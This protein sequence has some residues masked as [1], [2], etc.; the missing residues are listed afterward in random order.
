[1]ELFHEFETYMIY[2]AAFMMAFLLT[3]FTTPYIRKFAFKIG[4]VDHPKDRGMH[5]K[6]M[7][8]AGGIAI[9]LGFMITVIIFMTFIP[10][11]QITQM[12]G[13]MVGATLITIVG[14]LDDIY[15][16]S[17]RIRIV[18]QLL[19]ALIVLMTGTVMHS[20]T[21]PFFGIGTL[22]LGIFGDIIT[23]FWIVGITNAV[24]FLDGL[25]GLAAGVSSIASFSLLMI[26][27][28]FGDPIIAGFAIL[29]TATLAGS[30]L[31]FLPHNF[32]PATIFMGDTGSTFLGFTL[33][34]IS[35]QTMLKTYTAL[36]LLVAAIV[37]GL[38]LFDTIF[39]I[40]RRLIN[41]KPVT[42]ADR[43]H[44]HHRLIDK[45][46]SQKKAVFT[47]YFVSGLFGVAGVLIA[48]NDIALA[49]VIIVFIFV[50]WTFDI[51]RTHMKNRG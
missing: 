11:E 39:A 12:V 14:L 4:A 38:P 26:A 3:N 2:I 40:F 50:V 24:N 1:M 47:L 30:C 20:I 35:I 33:A 29:L 43:G 5:T 34:V 16:L 51:A 44:L 27:V 17:P 46:L 32:N 8:R 22:E 49:A 18:F 41:K 28:L 6:V 48:L 23:I 10:N 9:Y 25:D 21:I 15:S 19:S 37:L 36:T 7:P 13:L 45:G 31:G 42:E